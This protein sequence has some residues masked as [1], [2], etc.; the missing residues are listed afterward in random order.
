MKNKSKSNCH[1]PMY[2]FPSLASINLRSK[3]KSLLR[4]NP[5]PS[6]L[7]SYLC[8]LS[9]PPRRSGTERG[10]NNGE[11]DLFICLGTLPKAAGR[12]VLL[13]SFFHSDIIFKWEKVWKGSRP[14]LNLRGLSRP[15]NSFTRTHHLPNYSLPVHP[16]MMKNTT[17]TLGRTPSKNVH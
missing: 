13:P 3:W 9:D 5:P 8:L 17:S 4:A 16:W 1:H 10:P 6:L 7:S 14:H 12:Q 11:F 2:L 15:G